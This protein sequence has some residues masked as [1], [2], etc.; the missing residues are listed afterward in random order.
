V[1]VLGRLFQPI[2]MLVGKPTGLPY[3]GTPERCFAWVGSGRHSTMW[4]TFAKDK[5]SS[6]LQKLVK[7]SNKKFY[8]IDTGSSLFQNFFFDQKMIFNF[9]IFTAAKKTSTNLI[10]SDREAF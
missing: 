3:G 9:C 10:K 1:F 7:Y 6:L 4:E 8:N 5:H 2:P